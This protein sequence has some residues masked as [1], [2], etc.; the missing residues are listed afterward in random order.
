MLP[1][2]RLK[3][4][5]NTLVSV[6]SCLMHIF[7]RWTRRA[8]VQCPTP[9]VSAKNSKVASQT[10]ATSLS[11]TARRKPLGLA[12]SRST[13]PSSASTIRSSLFPKSYP[14]SGC[15]RSSRSTWLHKSSNCS[16]RLVCRTRYKCLSK[17]M[18]RMRYP[19][20]SCLFG[21]DYL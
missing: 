7:T 4:L 3:V 13:N 12:R 14:W 19:R 15:I 20:R 17:R 1:L 18:I 8:S 10:H 9:S 11:F 6:G 21:L 2:V 5:S 16:G